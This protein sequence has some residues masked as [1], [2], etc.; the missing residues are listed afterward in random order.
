LAT[1]AGPLC[2]EPMMGVGF[3][4]RSATTLENF[5][6]DELSVS[7]SV[8][9]Q[10][11]AAV[12]ESCR[13]AFQLH[14]QRLMAA[15]Y[16]CNIQVTAEMLGRLYG[17]LGKRCGRILHGDLQEGSA[18]FFVTAI[19]PVVE[20]FDFANEVRSK[21]SGLANP[22]LVFSHW[23]VISDDPYWEPRTEEEL[24]FFGE[25]GDSEIRA[26][27]YMNAV[28]R[29][30]GLPVNEKIVEFGEKQRTLTRNK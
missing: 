2:E 21:T 30:K 6:S 4:I 26:R 7:G 17:V 29:R 15:M 25:K 28:R 9:G 20:S 14:P 27:K 18:S 13:S 22:Q 24:L 1:K 11:M 12:K 3:I 5:K 16:A 23:E 10:L 19:L 8:K